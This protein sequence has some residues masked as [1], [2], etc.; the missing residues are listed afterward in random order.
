MYHDYFYLKNVSFPGELFQS[1]DNNTIRCLS[2]GHKCKILDKRSGICKVRYN[3]NG[4]LYVPYNYVCSINFDPIEKKPFFHVYPGSI[5]LSF[6]M[7]GC[8]FKCSFCQNWDISQFMRD[9]KA[10]GRIFKITPD[11]IIEL[12]KEKHIKI[13]T[14][15]YN[16]P[17]I[18]SEWSKKIFS[19]AKEFNILGAYVSNGYASKEVI[20]YLKGFVN[21][22]KIDLKSF[23]DKNYKKIGGKLQNV[24]DSI[25]YIYKQGIWI[26]IVTL[27]IP[28]Y[29]DSDE[30]IKN[31]A[32]FIY[33]ISPDIPWHITAFHPDYK[34]LDYKYTSSK[35]L[36]RAAKI[37]YNT[38]LKFVYTGN[39]PGGTENFENTYCPNCKKLLIERSGF[40]ILKNNIKNNICPNCSAPIAGFWV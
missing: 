39:I 20:N 8:N 37:G 6:G 14:S 34:M 11:K 21:F 9:A 18:T 4:I 17:L 26:E 23:N 15:T 25:E 5:T 12:A 38:G 28:N 29:N 13:I 27:L 19:I 40:R 16:E 31:I 35:D 1:I 10:E 7:L 3:E 36:I 32:G 30:E 2:C 33:N 22:F 24:L